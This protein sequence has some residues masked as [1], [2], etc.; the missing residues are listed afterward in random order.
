MDVSDR[1]TTGLEKGVVAQR[2]VLHATESRDRHGI[3]L[4]ALESLRAVSSE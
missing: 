3:L 1:A 4:Q 2:A